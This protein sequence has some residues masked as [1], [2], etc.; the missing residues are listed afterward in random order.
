MR[1][2]ALITLLVLAGPALALPP[3]AQVKSI[4]DGLRSVMIADQIR[5]VC[6]SIEARMIAG[7]SFVRSLQ[8]Q[9]RKLGYSEAEIEDFVESK[10][11]R[12][13]LEAEASAYMRAGGVKAGQP[14][15]YCALGRTEIAKGS[16]IG[17][18]L[19]AK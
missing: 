2:L 10:A 13:R 12:K 15:T 1:H 7:W 16:Q 11:E 6:P 3:L 19:R 18:L 14:E 4:N 8:Q 9:A 17:A 5:I